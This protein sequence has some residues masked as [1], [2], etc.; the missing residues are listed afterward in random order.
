LE[1]L[2]RFFSSRGFLEVETPLL[3]ADS[4]VDRHLDPFAVTLFADARQP[5]E[6]PTYWLQ[7][8]PEFC[9]KRLVAAYGVSV[10]Q[11][12]R[13]FRAGERGRHHNPEFTMAEWYEVGADMSRGMQRLSELAEELLQR[14][15]AQSISYRDAFTRWVGLDPFPAT[16][17]DLRGAA[18][19]GGSVPPAAFAA[20]DRDAWLEWLWVERVETHLGRQRPSIVYDYPASQAALARVREDDPPVAE[21]FELYVDGIELANGYCE[22]QDADVLRQRN[23]DNNGLRLRDGKYPLPEASRL[24]RAMQQ[25]LPACSGVALGFDRLVM[26]AGGAA[27]LDEVMAFP[28]ERA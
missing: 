15:A 4:V 1:R 28:I 13:A 21:R 14:G 9:M 22:L 25:G 2:R 16:C 6:G 5:G 10:Y 8:S 27:S 24:L 26:L 12:T 18:E 7:T 11:V 19:A 3:S 20:D 17:S 23:K